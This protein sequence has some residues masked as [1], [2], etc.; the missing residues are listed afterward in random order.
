MTGGEF[1]G[2]FVKIARGEAEISFGGS[3]DGGFGTGTRL[4][5]TA[6]AP[7]CHGGNDS[8]DCR[9]IIAFLEPASFHPHHV[10]VPVL[11]QKNEGVG[12]NLSVGPDV[13]QFVEKIVG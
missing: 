1:V 12:A 6:N 11:E 2:D 9:D 10:A 8:I 13:L 5:G 7:A 4:F 3:R